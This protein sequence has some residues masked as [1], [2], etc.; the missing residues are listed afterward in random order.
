MVFPPERCAKMFSV[1]RAPF[2]EEDEICA[3]YI[4]KR[5]RRAFVIRLGILKNR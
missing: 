4:S 3:G 5:K 1:T 2:A